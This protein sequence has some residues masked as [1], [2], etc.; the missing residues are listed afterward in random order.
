MYKGQ[1]DA[2]GKDHFLSGR[3]K[4]IPA[5]GEEKKK[6]VWANASAKQKATSLLGSKKREFSHQRVTDLLY[7]AGRGGTA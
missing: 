2:K 6:R 5:L 1:D 7:A 4:T 3:S